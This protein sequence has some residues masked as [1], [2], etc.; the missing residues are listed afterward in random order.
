[1][2]LEMTLL[3]TTAATLGLVTFC[4]TL[5]CRQKQKKTRELVESAGQQIADLEKTLARTK[6]SLDTNTQRTA[7]QSRRIAWLETRIRKPNSASSE[8][9]DDEIISTESQKLNMTERRHRVISLAS[10]GQH[11]DAIAAT[12]GMLPGEVEL[13]V[14]LNQAVWNK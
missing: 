1:M 11:T 9:L 4:F 7:E 10:R 3:L 5:Y 13:I 12:L 6:E 2:N 14:N 8:V